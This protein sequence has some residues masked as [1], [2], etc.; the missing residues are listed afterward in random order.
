MVPGQIKNC[1]LYPE[2]LQEEIT[3]DSNCGTNLTR[4]TTIKNWD[5]YK[6]NW[7]IFVNL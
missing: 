2:T 4:K 6:K 7:N 1:L 5:N 3:K